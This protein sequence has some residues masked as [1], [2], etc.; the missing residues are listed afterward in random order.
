MGKRAAKAASTPVLAA[1]RAS[2]LFGLPRGMVHADAVLGTGRVRG[3]RQ[4]LSEPSRE[5]RPLGVG[6]PPPPAESVTTTLTM[7]DGASGSLTFRNNLV[8]D[9]KDRV[10]FPRATDEDGRPFTFRDLQ[11]WRVPLDSPRSVRGTVAYLSDTGVHNFGHWFLF[12][13]P[14]VRRYREYLGQ[15]P[16]FFYIGAPIQ[17]WHYDSLAACGIEPRQLLTEPVAGDRMLAAIV[18]RPVPPP[19]SFLDFSTETLRRP[20]GSGPGRRVYISRKRQAIRGLVNEAACNEVLEQHGFEPYFTEALTLQEET[21]LFASADA[22]VAL[23]GAG[24]ANLLF[25]HP[26]CVAV[27][28]FPHGFTSSWFSDVSAARGLRYACLHGEPTRTMGLPSKSR[29]ALI[30]PSK[31]DAV[32]TAATEAAVGLRHAAAE[33]PLESPAVD[34][35]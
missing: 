25:C 16:D 18:D 11:V 28:L 20:R 27:E 23:H 34:A 4:D 3:G 5:V 32:L 6:D 13:Y 31:L 22:V 12:I 35:P 2:T 17:E 10:V 26:S 33:A 19:R 7:L 21:E 30:D 14:L 24:L 8:V 1:A 9:E 29:D 15:D